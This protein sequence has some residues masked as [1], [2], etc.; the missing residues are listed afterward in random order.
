MEDEAFILVRRWGDGFTFLLVEPGT[1]DLTPP[2]G[3]KVFYTVN[4]AINAAKHDSE[5]G[6]LVHPECDEESVKLNARRLD[7]THIDHY[8]LIAKNTRDKILRVNHSHDNV[9]VKTVM[10]IVNYKPEDKVE[11]YWAKS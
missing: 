9:E 11:I 4:D 2:I 7:H 8:L 3:S 10:A 1:T 5:N 6:T